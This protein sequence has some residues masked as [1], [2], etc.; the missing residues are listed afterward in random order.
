MSLPSEPAKFRWYYIPELIIL[1][2][3]IPVLYL[4]DTIPVHKVIPLVALLIYCGS[5]LLIK[6]PANASCFSI[7]ANWKIIL[8]LFITTSIAVYLF[9]YLYVSKGLFA[10]LPENRKLLYMILMYP[11][12]SAF[13]QE[14]I[15]REFFFYRYGTL[16]RNPAWMVAVNML[17]FTFAHIYFASSIVI[18][19]TLVAG[20][21]FAI[22]YMRTRSLLVVS[23][24]HSLYG[25]MIL[26]SGL[27][28]HF[29]KAF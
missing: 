15:F 23:I 24:Q 7:K 4:F 18:I 22:T 5:I 25:L 13:P 16:F 1:F 14:V 27:A 12:L 28:Q 10:D 3:V 6:K 9:I 21:I 8:A 26:T 29:Y 17:L 20:T 2:I 19:F 11:L